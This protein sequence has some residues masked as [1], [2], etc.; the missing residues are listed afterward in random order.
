MVNTIFNSFLGWLLIF[1]SKT[2]HI[3][4]AEAASST[5]G[6]AAKELAAT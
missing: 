1:S 5:L 3:R 6:A 2:R 4:K